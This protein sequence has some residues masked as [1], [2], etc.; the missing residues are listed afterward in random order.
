[1]FSD[2]T[3]KPHG[4]KGREAFSTFKVNKTVT[5]FILNRYHINALFVTIQLQ[6]ITKYHYEAPKVTKNLPLAMH[7]IFHSASLRLPAGRQVQYE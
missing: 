3:K 2:E 4:F 5:H 1:M 7:E 6:V